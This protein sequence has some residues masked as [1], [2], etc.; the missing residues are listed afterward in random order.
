MKI[1]PKLINETPVSSDVQIVPTG[2]SANIDDLWRYTEADIL[3]SEASFFV[4]HAQGVL[5]RKP[6]SP[7]LTLEEVLAVRE[8]V[9]WKGDPL[10]DADWAT[11][12]RLE[13]LKIV[14]ARQGKPTLGLDGRPVRS[15]I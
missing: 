6:P 10:R 12:E 4:F 3:R 7:P 5:H 11:G 1:D 2:E 15:M 14:L 13:A 8:E 9:F